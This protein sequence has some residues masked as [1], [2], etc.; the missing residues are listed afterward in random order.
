MKCRT[1]VQAAAEDEF[2]FRR[3]GI[4]DLLKS[5][6]VRVGAPVLLRRQYSAFGIHADIAHRAANH[7]TTASAGEPS[8]DLAFEVQRRCLIDPFSRAGQSELVSFSPCVVAEHAEVVTGPCD[9]GPRAFRIAY[10]GAASACVD[11]HI[12]NTTV[13]S[14]DG[15][16]RTGREVIVTSQRAEIC[17][18]RIRCAVG[19][20]RKT[21]GA[22]LGLAAEGH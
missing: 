7:K 12:L 2:Q 5:G 9:P 1:T 18:H 6:V 15:H 22:S 21:K 10:L 13:A 8:V 17:P 20:S 19:H 16:D 11:H 3:N 4:V 14:L